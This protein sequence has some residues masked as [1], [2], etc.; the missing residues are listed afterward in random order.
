MKHAKKSLYALIPLFC[1]FYS[2]AMEQP[3]PIVALHLNI[4]SKNASTSH[5]VS[6]ALEFSNI[7]K[8]LGSQKMSDMT[9]LILNAHN[10]GKK[11]EE[12]SHTTTG[13]IQIIDKLKKYLHTEYGIIIPA[14]SYD[15]LI[16]LAIN[17][18][19]DYTV[20][21]F[22]KALKNEQYTTLGISDHDCTEH[23]IYCKKMAEQGVNIDDLFT[24]ILLLYPQDSQNE[25]DPCKEAGNVL[26]T[27]HVYPSEQSIHNINHI[28]SVLTKNLAPHVPIFIIDSYVEAPD[29]FRSHHNMT[30]IPCVSPDKL[31]TI[32]KRIVS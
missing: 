18:Q 24:N 31:E 27:H 6:R 17:P 5:I 29:A 2:G 23:K 21:Q 25:F 13:T 12:F 22:L 11:A 26:L 14:K 10:I 32:L 8:I 30:H 20:V 1:T 15:M 28:A 9:S 16:D 3:K 4:L 7:S 19:P